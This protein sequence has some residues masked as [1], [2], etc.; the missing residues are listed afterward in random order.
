MEKSEEKKYLEQRAVKIRIQMQ[1]M[2]EKN[3][4]EME[5]LV[6]KINAYQK[7]Q[8]KERVR[9]Q[10]VLLQRCLNQKNELIQ[11]Q[12]LEKSK[13]AHTLTTKNYASTIVGKLDGAL[14]SMTAMWK[15]KS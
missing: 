2:I 13:L 6:K 4:N 1:H 10:Q 15:E 3:K 7:D 14:R 11:Q 8:D 5:V 9:Q 12:R